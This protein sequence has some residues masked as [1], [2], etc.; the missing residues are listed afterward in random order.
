MKHLIS[1]ATVILV[2]MT[3]SDAFAQLRIRYERTG[4]NYRLT[5][6]YSSGSY[7][8]YGYGYGYGGTRYITPGYG[9]GYGIYYG[10]GSYAGGSY[11][12]GYY[13]P[14]V[15]YHYRSGGT[16]YSR[17]LRRGHRYL[18]A[19][20]VLAGLTGDVSYG[21]NAVERTARAERDQTA[22]EKALLDGR[23]LDAVN[24]FRNA[25][26]ELDGD[27]PA[28]IAFGLALIGSGDT[29]AGI[30]A[31]SVSLSEGSD[32]LGMN[33]Q[34]I[35]P[36]GA[37]AELLRLAQPYLDPDSSSLD[38]LL[39]A[40]WLTRSGGENPGAWLDRYLAAGGDRATADQLRR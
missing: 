19:G 28:K 13:T 18:T 16:Y 5:A 10:G 35:L 30:Q 33:A 2:L 12:G 17:E 1:M 39:A 25:V 15:R 27:Q 3:A 29:W 9:S 21:S 22:G 24:L 36:A 40:A 23:Y 26:R 38:H 37:A 32:G 6:T 7:R 20:E 4:D 31:L 34:A 8:S 14:V 11:Y